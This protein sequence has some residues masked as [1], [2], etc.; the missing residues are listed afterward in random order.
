MIA[1]IIDGRMRIRNSRLKESAF[2]G[3][4]KS[5]LSAAKGLKEILINP[6]VGS[7][8]LVYDTSIT[9]AERIIK[10]IGSLLDV[11]QETEIP[12]GKKANVN[13]RRAI[14]IGLLASLAASLIALVFGSKALH[15]VFGLAFLSFAAVHIFKDGK[16]LLA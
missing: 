9:S 7:A 8:L 12:K 15:A 6:R 5:H 4:L 2:A 11:T 16:F 10:R 1:S 3:E 14:S 13:T